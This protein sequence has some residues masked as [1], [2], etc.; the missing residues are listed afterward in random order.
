[1]KTTKV[2]GAQIICILVLLLITNTLL[3]DR[4]TGNFQHADGCE[5]FREGWQV[6]VGDEVRSYDK[7][8]QILS[9]NGHNEIRLNRTV[10]GA[11][12]IGLFAFQQQIYVYLDGE[13]VFRFAPNENVNSKTPGNGWQFIELASY[14]AGKELSICIVQCYKKN[15]VN[16]PVLYHGTKMSITLH[17]LQ[18]KTFLLVI[19][20]IGVMVGLFLLLVWGIAGQS[21]Q[22]N[23]GLP[24]LALFAV[25]IGTWSV[26]EANVYSFFFDKLLL[27]SWISYICLKMS[28]VPFLMFVN[29]TFHNGNSK[30]LRGLIAFSCAEFW[31][32]SF[33]QLT[34]IMDYA[35]TAFVTHG[36]LCVSSI[37]IMVTAVPK[38]FS[39]KKNWENMEDHKVTY[40][41]HSVFI[42]VVAVTSMMDMYRFYFSNNPD[43][44]LYSRIGYFGYVLAVTI[45]SLM[46]FISLIVMGKQAALIKQE[47]SIDAMTKLHNRAEFEKD[48]AKAS[49]NSKDMG[50]VMCDLNDL[51]KF[52][53]VYGHDM[54]DF[55]I[56]IGSEVIQDIFGQWGKLYRIGGDEFCGIVKGLTE[57]A[58]MKAQENMEGRMKALHVVGYDLHMEVSSGYAVF[59]Q[60]RDKN[61]RDTMKRA[62]ARMYQRKKQLKE[63]VSYSEENLFKQ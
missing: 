11:D 14:D 20:L 25:F 45:A 57:D 50:I 29:Y 17:Y 61:L 24:W 21:L 60:G 59:D 10:Q 27:F 31:V 53:D 48:I 34:G 38:L 52:N 33:L 30:L 40:T 51:K 28:V 2:Y 47:A 56:I 35:D 23:R 36:I 37:Y 58:F 9:T 16:I 7:L 49:K 44:A 43:I 54:G 19:S 55:Y 62:D 3:S 39:K 26:I 63:G 46:D 1:M 12:T 6:Y 42:V 5:A 4:F 15:K 13:E 8:P 32:S 22:L 41:V 18:S